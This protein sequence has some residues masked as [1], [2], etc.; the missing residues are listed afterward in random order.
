M[1]SW[2]PRRAFIST[3]P[4]SLAANFLFAR[5][6]GA[7]GTLQ[8]LYREVPRKAGFWRGCARGRIRIYF[9]F[10]GKYFFS[11]RGDH[12]VV[13]IH[14]FVEMNPRDLRQQLIGV[15]FRQTVVLVDPVH[16]FGESDAHARHP[17]DDRRPRS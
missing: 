5:D 4:L 8:G 10:A 13:R 2:S 6:S 11:I 3:D 7:S 14:H 16:E 17:E 15:E 12:H 1:I 9:F